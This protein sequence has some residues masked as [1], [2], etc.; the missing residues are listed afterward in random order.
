[1]YVPYLT[2]KFDKLLLHHPTIRTR[3]ILAESLGVTPPN[4]SIWQS[5]DDHRK[6]NQIP[7]KHI[8]RLCELFDIEV[9]WLAIEDMDYFATLLMQ[10]ARKYSPW[11]QLLDHRERSDALM[12]QLASSQENRLRLLYQEQFEEKSSRFFVLFQRVYVVLDLEKLENPP[13]TFPQYLTL[14]ATGSDYRCL[15]P[16]TAA[17]SP[18]PRLD[19]PKLTIPIGAPENYLIA[20][21]TGSHYLTALL[22]DQP[23]SPRVCSELAQART[24]DLKPIL[25]SVANSLL[26]APPS[27]WRILF[28][29][30]AVY[31]NPKMSDPEYSLK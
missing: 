2:Q 20:E 8:P 19:Q 17:G 10:N 18:E 27:T 28:W 5:G 1:M 21:E 22:T 13:A 9:E 31:A 16:A 15:C 29:D 30:Y 14:I 6:P 7:E 12:L 11:H 25:D 23:L 26:N 24:L 4:I 3:T